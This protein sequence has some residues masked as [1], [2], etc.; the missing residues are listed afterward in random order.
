MFAIG[1]AF[2]QLL[3]KPLP[4]NNPHAWDDANKQYPSAKVCGQCHPTQYEQWKISSHAY[5]N[6]S[7]MFNKFEQTINDLSSGTVNYFCV[8]CHASVGTALGEKRDI[9]WWDRAPAAREGITCVTCHR[10]GEGYGKFNGARRITPGE[11]SEAVHG[12]FDTTG[13]LKAITNAATY[14]ILVSPDEKDKPEFLRIHQQ[15]VRSEILVK[16]EFCVTCHQVQVHPGIK[17]E[18]VWEE[19]RNSPARKEGTTCQQCHMSK[20]PGRDVGFD[21]GYAAVVNGNTVG[22]RPLTDHRFIGP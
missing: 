4:E 20:S 8:R 14:G 1:T 12:P 5:A 16:S 10:A 11:I 15:A 6:L 2:G 22:V 7:P 18:T 13:V 17:L 9:A 21:S 19:Y 3:P